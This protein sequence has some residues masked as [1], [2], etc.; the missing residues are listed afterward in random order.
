MAELRLTDTI[1]EK[2][3]LIS[4]TVKAIEFGGE[5]P[6][7]R[8]L[9]TLLRQHLASLVVLFER[10]PGLDAAT[11]DLYAAAAAVVNDTARA[12]QPFAR[13][14]RLLKEAQVR[15]QERIATARPNGR[16]V[17]AAWRQNELFLAA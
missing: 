13:K 3:A 7:L 10:D 5:L 8:E 9:Q 16:R 6:Y 12:S 17:C 4:P 14:R 2:L 1:E 15:F 11:T